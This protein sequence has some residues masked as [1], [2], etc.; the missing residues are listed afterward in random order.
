MNENS[1]G[2][3]LLEGT[4]DDTVPHSV[5]AVDDVEELRAERD[6]LRETVESGAAELKNLARLRDE[7][8]STAS[9]DLKSPLTSILGGAQM[10]ERLLTEPNIDTEK[11]IRWARVIQDQA[12]SMTLMV[13]DLLDASRVQSG[14]F[15]LRLSP[16]VLDECVATAMGRLGPDRQARIHIEVPPGP[17]GGLWDRHRIEQVLSNLV[18]NALKYSPD[19]DLI[20]VTAE[21]QPQEVEVSVNDRGVGIPGRE[22][23]RL[24]QRFYRTA[25]ATAGGVPG[26]GL[27][28]FI[29]EQIITAHGGRLWAESLGTGY[30]STFRFTLP[31]TPSASASTPPSREQST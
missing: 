23:S 5:H 27:G 8:I 24:F 20:R 4:P 2:D 10:V 25:E 6:A 30:G 3:E 7:F 14:A 17:I 22:L 18:D 11:T 12:R 26:T 15:H 29:C 16:C 21:A 28:L 19:G 9:H 31:I 13:N 1:D